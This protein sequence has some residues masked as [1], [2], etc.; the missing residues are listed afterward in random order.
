MTAEHA[1]HRTLLDFAIDPDHADRV[2]SA[3][4][5]QSI[6]RLKQDGHYRCWVCGSEDNIE[7][8]H[9]AGE[10]MFANVLDFAKVQAFCEEWDVYGYGRLLKARPL[11]S[12]DDVRNCMCLCA[13]HHRL[14]NHENGGSGTGIH[15]CSFPTWLA[16]KLALDGANPVPQPGETFAQALARIKAHEKP[17]ASEAA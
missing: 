5:R 11:T 12:L 17:E 9:R 16:Q 15:A 14:V 8:H 10:Y 13:S 2:E 7:V 6:A 3:E 4:F 1:E